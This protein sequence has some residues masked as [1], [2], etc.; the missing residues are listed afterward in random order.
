MNSLAGQGVGG[1]KEVV[2]AKQVVDE[3]VAGAKKI[4]LG[5]AAYV[6]KL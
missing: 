3:M 5:G 6:S 4:L 2:P 1:I